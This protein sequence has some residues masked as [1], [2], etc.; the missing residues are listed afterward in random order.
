MVRLP[1]QDLREAHSKVKAAVAE[2]LQGA[3]PSI[4]RTVLA[5]AD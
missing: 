5:Y 4:V 2:T 3:E 1:E